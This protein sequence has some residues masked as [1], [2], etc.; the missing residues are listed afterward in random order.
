MKPTKIVFHHSATPSSI[1]LQDSL[2]SF[3]YNH[4]TR[5]WSPKS[6]LWRHV[7][8][9]FVIAANGNHAQCRDINEPWRHASNLAVNNSSI[10]IC[11]IG[12]FENESPTQAQYEK[13]W[14]II[15]RLQKELWIKLELKF[16]NEYANKK[17]P[18]A[19]FDVSMVKSALDLEKHTPLFYSE[20]FYALFDWKNTTFLHPKQAEERIIKIYKQKWA[21][22]MIQEMI[23]LIA[24]L[25]TKIDIASLDPS[26]DIVSNSSPCDND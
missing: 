12:N 16:H 26:S 19:N 21:E 11:L 15:N 25:M 24:I 5:I 1:G 17:C 14:K 23:A 20:L 9:H 8:Y 4:K 6:K 22:T 18:W 7:T 13:C 3:D 2:R 10:A